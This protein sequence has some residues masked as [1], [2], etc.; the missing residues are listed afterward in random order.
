MHKICIMVWIFINR[1]SCIHSTHSTYIY[2]IFYTHGHVYK[3]FRS[4]FL[5]YMKY[6]YVCVTFIIPHFIFLYFVL[7]PDAR[8]R[9]NRRTST[10]HPQVRRNGAS[11]DF[12]SFF[13]C[14]KSLYYA[15]L[16]QSTVD[17][18]CVCTFRFFNF[19]SSHVNCQLPK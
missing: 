10:P 8:R 14:K 16:S 13:H 12:L 7:Y 9:Q 5:S 2:T 17:L 19:L 11:S 4:Y 15:S 3:I 1:I 18:C 6:K